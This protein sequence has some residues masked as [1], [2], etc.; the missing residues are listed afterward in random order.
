MLRQAGYQVIEK[1]QCDFNQDK[2]TDPQLKSFLQDLEMVPPLEPRDAFYG[3]RTAA[4]TLYAKGDPGE[5]IKYCDVTSP[6]PW[7][8]NCKE[9]P[10]RFPIIYTNPSQQDIDQYFGVAQVDILAPEHLYHPV[11]PVHSNGK[12]T[13]PLCASWVREEQA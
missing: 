1:W 13:F 8:N 6:Y 12:L 5:D 10:V 11:L 3:V 7:V 9:Y 2:K 4:A